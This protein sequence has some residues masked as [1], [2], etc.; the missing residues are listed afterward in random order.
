MTVPS[1]S[2]A[3]NAEDVEKMLRMPVS[4]EGALPPQDEPP[5]AVTVPSLSNAANA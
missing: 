2:N 1:L 3:A 5:H 4:P